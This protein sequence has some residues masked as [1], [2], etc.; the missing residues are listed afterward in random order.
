[1]IALIMMNRRKSYYRSQHP[2]TSRNTDVDVD[3]DGAK[4]IVRK[5]LSPKQKFQHIMSHAQTVMLREMVRK[6][7]KRYVNE[8]I[9]DDIAYTKEVGRRFPDK[10]VLKVLS[11]LTDKQQK[12]LFQEA[13]TRY[14]ANFDRLLQQK[15]DAGYSQQLDPDKKA[16]I[17]TKITHI[18]PLLK[19]ILFKPI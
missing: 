9:R 5:E 10:H 8:Y 13:L 17:Y 12:E 16:N 18:Q 3:G 2:Y 1:M 6:T 19:Y 4:E 7:P 15:L 11:Q 14:E